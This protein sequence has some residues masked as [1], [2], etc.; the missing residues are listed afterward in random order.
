[1]GLYTGEA[2]AVD[3][4]YHSP[5]LNRVPVLCQ[6]RLPGESSGVDGPLAFGSGAHDLYKVLEVGG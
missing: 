3:G 6:L 5:V 4:D 2:S 1:M